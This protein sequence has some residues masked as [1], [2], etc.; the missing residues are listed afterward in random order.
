M[1]QIIHKATLHLRVTEQSGNHVAEDLL[2]LMLLDQKTFTTSLEEL[3]RMRTLGIKDTIQ[4]SLKFSV[5]DT[6]EQRLGSHLRDIIYA[7]Q[8]TLAHIDTIVYASSP[9][10]FEL[11]AKDLQTNFSLPNQLLSNTTLSAITSVFSP[12]TNAH[13]LIRYL[14]DSVQQYTPTLEDE[15]LD[16]DKVRAMA[17]SWL[18]ELLGLLKSPLPDMLSPLD[19]QLKLVQ[20]RSKVWQLLES[21]EASWSKVCS[22]VLGHSYS[23]WDSMFK[24]SFDGHAKYLIDKTLK[25]LSD[26]PSTL[27]SSSLTAKSNELSTSLWPS[28]KTRS[29]ASDSLLSLS[30]VADMRAFKLTL[31]KLAQGETSWIEQGYQAFETTL[32]TIRKDQEAHASFS[33]QD[34]F[35]AKQ[36]TQQ[37]W[38]YF[39]TNVV[40]A[41]TQYCGSLRTLL[42]KVAEWNNTKQ[43]S[44]ASLL[45]GR[46]ARSLAQHSQSL[47]LVLTT[48]SSLKLQSAIDKDPSYIGLQNDFMRL[49]EE[50]HTPWIKR[51]VG[52]FGSLVGDALR[53][54]TWDEHCAAVLLWEDTE[55]GP[56]P[57]QATHPTVRAL[58]GVCEEMQR[59]Q[60]MLL[61]KKVIHSLV[62]QLLTTLQE[63][64]DVFLEGQTMT[65]RGALQLMFDLQFMGFVLRQGGRLNLDGVKKHVDPINW[66]AFSPHFNARIERFYLKQAL[67][68]HTLTCLNGEVFESNKAVTKGLVQQNQ[69]NVLPMVS[70]TTRFTL[71]PIGQLTHASR[72]W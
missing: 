31:T 63:T 55:E 44:E 40:R 53:T 42:A 67:F 37:L 18:K 71:L 5:A 56:L 10:A 41:I 11:Y 70:T 1:P 2:V 7:I 14:P 61:N 52:S 49:F 17:Q 72:A 39:Q 32:D 54:T 50:A 6:A 22:R 65:E 4:A 36:S 8:R 16:L 29:A 43:A 23:L 15:P 24:D 33:T 69:P 20:T 38:T 30:S 57:S 48:L 25:S 62:N 58:F 64:L 13:L 45:I 59:I 19:T 34:S 9:S 28:S 12:S 51:A 35:G 68:L 26:Q 47:P 66:A 60:M 21:Q 3:F 46:L 27:L